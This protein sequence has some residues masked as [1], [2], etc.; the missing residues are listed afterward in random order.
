MAKSK[1]S[2]P[3]R[4]MSAHIPEGQEMAE[5]VERDTTA[6]TNDLGDGLHQTSKTFGT[7][8]SDYETDAAGLTPEKMA[9]RSEK[10]K[11]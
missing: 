6:K 1:S 8:V 7:V 4:D 2:T 11:K 3:E 5:N 9:E 10:D